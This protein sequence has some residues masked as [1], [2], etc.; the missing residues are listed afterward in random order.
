MGRVISRQ[1]PLLAI[2]G[3]DD[4]FFDAK[5]RGHQV[6]AVAVQTIGLVIHRAFQSVSLPFAEIRAGAEG[7][8][9][10]D[11]NGA[12][13]VALG[14]PKR[15][16]E[17]DALAATAR[18]ICPPAQG[19]GHHAVRS[20]RFNVLI[21]HPAIRLGLLVPAIIGVRVSEDRQLGVIPGGKTGPIAARPKAGDPFRS[22]GAFPVYEQTFW[23]VKGG[24]KQ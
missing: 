13:L 5:I 18:S 4:V 1:S 23:R 17:G 6:A 22:H 16:Q 11:D 12:H 10:G 24:H 20:C 3:G 21:G 15:G 19:D 2:D 9:A 7:V 8:G 14:G